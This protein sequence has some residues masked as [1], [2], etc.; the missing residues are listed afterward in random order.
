MQALIALATLRSARDDDPVADLYALDHGTHGLDDA[1]A[2]MIGNL[3]SADGVGPERTAHNGVT[4]R[5]GLGT[6][7]HLAW[8]DR[9]E[10]HLLNIERVGMAD[11]APERPSRLGSGRTPGACTF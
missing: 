4:G 11:E 3:R 10:T 1:K 9:Q 2:A 5:D 8:I 6:D 7:H